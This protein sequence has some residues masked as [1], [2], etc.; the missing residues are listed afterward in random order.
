MDVVRSMNVARDSMQNAEN[1]HRNM[2]N[3]NDRRR[4]EREYIGLVGVPAVWD[5]SPPQPIN[6]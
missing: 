4:K 1:S 6:E 3:H 5:K 2:S